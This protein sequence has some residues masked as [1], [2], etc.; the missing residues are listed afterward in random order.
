MN[1]TGG[2][3][4]S[5]EEVRGTAA[6]NVGENAS[7]GS[8][9]R[10]P[11]AGDC[12]ACMRV[13]QRR[14][15]RIRD[16][17]DLQAF[18]ADETGGTW[19]AAREVPG[20]A[21]LNAGGNAQATSVSCATP[22]N[23]AA[24][25]TYAGASTSLTQQAFLVNETHGTW[26]KAEEVPGTAPAVAK[27]DSRVTSV[28]CASAGNCSAGG[29]EDGADA[30]P[31][32]SERNWPGVR[33]GRDRRLLGRPR[34]TRCPGMATINTNPYL[35]PRPRSPA[36]R[37]PTAPPQAVRTRY[38]SCPP[39]PYADPFVVD[40][41][42]PRRRRRRRRRLSALRVAYGDEEDGALLGQGHRRVGRNAPTG[43]V[44]HR[45]GLRPPPARSPSCRALRSCAPAATR[46]PASTPV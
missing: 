18:V 17:R 26:G 13:L 39:G 30:A 1:E 5:A 6:L 46:L 45:V 29:Y 7:V 34:R 43:T 4:G 9:F 35:P 3:W 2:V 20:T 31:R 36:S 12:T 33:R 27:D 14:Q 8:G 32:S 10:R 40:K 19:R 42:G 16:P 41:V 23:C 25:G 44:I 28:S 11:A 38:T 15:G 21:A 37:R 24:G 22:G